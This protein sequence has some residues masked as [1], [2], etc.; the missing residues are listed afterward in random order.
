MDLIHTKKTPKNIKHFITE[1]I[2]ETR[3]EKKNISKNVKAQRDRISKKHPN[4]EGMTPHY[5]AKIQQ[6]NPLMD[7][8]RNIF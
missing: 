7:Y 3:K 6:H 4:K 1:I 5:D 8:H 2:A